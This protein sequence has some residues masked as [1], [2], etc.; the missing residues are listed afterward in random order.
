[1]GKPISLDVAGV[2]RHC[3]RV[4]VKVVVGGVVA[5]RL[6]KLGRVVVAVVLRNAALPLVL[7]SA[8]GV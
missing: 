1:M 2:A 7:L 3:E 8:L 6:V 4:L 5:V